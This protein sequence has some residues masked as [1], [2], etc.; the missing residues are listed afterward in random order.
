VEE[1]WEALHFLGVQFFSS[2]KRETIVNNGNKVTGIYQ[3]N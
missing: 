1:Q 2:Q 3:V